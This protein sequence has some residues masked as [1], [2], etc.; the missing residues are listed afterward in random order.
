MR[1]CE[2]LQNC[3]C[4]RAFDLQR[5]SPRTNS[6]YPSQKHFAL[7]STRVLKTRKHAWHKKNTAKSISLVNK[8]SMH[9]VG[10]WLKLSPRFS[11]ERTCRQN[12]RYPAQRFSRGQLCHC[13]AMGRAFFFCIVFAQKMKQMPDVYSFEA[14]C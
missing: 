2:H 3:K 14:H 8:S 6:D 4:P 10:I 7:S 1:H 13:S 5:K 11:H 12:Q 9:F